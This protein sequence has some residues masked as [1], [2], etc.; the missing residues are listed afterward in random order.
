MLNAWLIVVALAAGT[1]A[2]SVGTEMQLAHELAEEGDREACLLECRRVAVH[3]PAR[4]AA[5]EA[6]ATAAGATR[7]HRP[8]R[9]SWWRRL[10]A[11]PIKG[12][13]TFYRSTVAPALG[14][15]CVLHPSCSAYSLQAAQERGW[16]GIPMTADRLI[17]EPSVVHAR[18]H[19]VTIPDG[20]ILYADPVAHH[21]GGR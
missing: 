14:S 20:R 8:T 13:V 16:I 4:R 15:R 9:S 3:Y 7:S 18:E 21:I 11:L 6:L 12:L 17:R 10:G 5:A 1:P 19:P 2:S